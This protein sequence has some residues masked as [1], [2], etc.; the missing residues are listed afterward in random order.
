MNDKPFVNSNIWIYLFDQDESRKQT[1]LQLLADEP[2]ISTQVIRRKYQRL[3]KK[4]QTAS[5]GSGKPH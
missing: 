1:A 3:Y 4:T 2:M 5:A